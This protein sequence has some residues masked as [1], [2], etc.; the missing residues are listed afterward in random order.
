MVVVIQGTVGGVNRQAAAG[1]VTAQMKAHV[2]WGSLGDS[3][4]PLYA[5][6]CHSLAHHMCWVSLHAK[7]VQ[8]VCLSRKQ[9]PSCFYG[10]LTWTQFSCM[11]RGD[12]PANLGT[13]SC[14]KYPL[15]R[16]H[17]VDAESSSLS[18]STTQVQHILVCTK[19]RL[20]NPVW[21]CVA[22]IWQQGSV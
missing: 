8:T 14:R 15:Q 3:A 18:W 5:K 2:A 21:L 22:E 17:S 12:I 7:C 11:Q 16:W 4:V 1:L 6:H 10:I 13:P 20:L 9:Y 19:Q